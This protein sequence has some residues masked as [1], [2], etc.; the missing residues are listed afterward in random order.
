M[1]GPLVGTVQPVELLRPS[2]Y[3]ADVIGGALM[4][5]GAMPLILRWSTPFSKVWASACCIRVFLLGPAKDRP[6][7][8]ASV[9]RRVVGLSASDWL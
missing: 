3:S 5:V 7:V 4:S 2:V 9:P 6:E 8:Y 1:K